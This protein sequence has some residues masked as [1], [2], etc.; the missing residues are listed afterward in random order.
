MGRPMIEV[1]EIKN[2]ESLVCFLTGSP[3]DYN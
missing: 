1:K 2:E 3:S